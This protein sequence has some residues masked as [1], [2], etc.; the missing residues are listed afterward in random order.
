MADLTHDTAQRPWLVGLTGGIGS[1]K[2]TVTRLLAGLGAEII[3][4]DVISRELLAPGS[5]LLDEIAGQFGPQLLHNGELDRARLRALVFGDEQARRW[6]E[7][8]LHPRIREE[9]LR[10]IQ[11]SSRS[12]LVVAAPLLV[13]SGA[14]DFVDCVVVVDTPESLQLART[15]ARDGVPEEQVRAIMELQLPRAERLKAAHHIIHNDG[16]IVD[17]REQVARLY[18]RFEETARV[19][20]QRSP[21]P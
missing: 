12:W 8:L 18:Q 15:A 13:E 4:A 7:D 14:Y 1:G 17:L 10:R 21:L 2:T 19:R 6:L 16:D 5:P 11:R 9:I 3:D 20:S